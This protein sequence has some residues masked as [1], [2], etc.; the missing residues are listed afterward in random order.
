M[1]AIFTLVLWLANIAILGLAYL[2]YRPKRREK[3]KPVNQEFKVS[4]VKMGVAIPVVFG[5]AKLGGLMIEWG[6]WTVIPHVEV[7]EM[8]KK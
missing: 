6:G 3:Q 5:Y 1:F 2:M 8:S 7:H 4:G